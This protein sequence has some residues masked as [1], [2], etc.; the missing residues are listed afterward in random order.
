MPGDAM[1]GHITDLNA[2]LRRVPHPAVVLVTNSEG[3]K[4]CPVPVGG[5]KWVFLQETILALDPIKLEAQDKTGKTL[6]VCEFSADDADGAPLTPPVPLTPP[7]VVEDP[8][9]VFGRLLAANHDRA[10]QAF[11]RGAESARVAYEHGA[12]SAREASNVA[13][14]KLMELLTLVMQRQSM[15]ERF[16]SRQHAEA[17]Q[18]IEEA[19]L[20]AETNAPQ[21]NVME[22]VLAQLAPGVI[23]NVMNGQGGPKPPPQGPPVPGKG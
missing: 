13:N 20:E 5:K 8:L 23:A 7:G 3:T 1:N 10:I 15:L 6:R 17:I 19:E 14:E 18:R 12:G 2:W 21:G 9:I 11:E 16:L 4:T 22:Q